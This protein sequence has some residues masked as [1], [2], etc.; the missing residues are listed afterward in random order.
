MT[1]RQCGQIKLNIVITGWQ[2]LEEI[3]A[4]AVGDFWADRI[5]SYICD[6]CAIAI[7][8]IDGHAL[9]TRFISRG[10]LDAILVIVIPNSITYSNRQIDACI[11]SGI[12]FARSQ[13]CDLG[14]TCDW[15]CIRV[16]LVTGRW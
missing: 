2:V 5:A 1:S 11:P 10:I 3:V 4:I 16:D 6:R 15:I 14:L 12:M 13:R 8:Y 7:E 9:N